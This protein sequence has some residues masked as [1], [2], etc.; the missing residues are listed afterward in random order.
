M[1][2]RPERLPRDAKCPFCEQSVEP[3]FLN[4]SQLRG[5]LTERGKIVS[6]SR[7]GVCLAHQ[8]HLAQAIKRARYM[9][10]IPFVSIAR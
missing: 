9:A 10:L 3:T 8:R 2:R 4:P 7:S 6:R 1:I 5:L